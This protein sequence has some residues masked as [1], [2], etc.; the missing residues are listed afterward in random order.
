MSEEIKTMD[1][2][3]KQYFIAL[4][5]I[6]EEKDEGWE[7]CEKELR[8]SFEAAKKAAEAGNAAGQYNLAMHYD[9]DFGVEGTEEQA[10]EWY[11]K[12]AEQGHSEA[13]HYTAWAYLKGQGVKPDLA[14]H[15]E[16]EKKAAFAYYAESKTA[17]AD[18]A[19][20]KIGSAIHAVRFLA[21]DPPDAEVIA[22]FAQMR[23]D[24]KVQ[25]YTARRFSADPNFLEDLEKELKAESKL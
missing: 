18:T 1:Y 12:A 25:A 9:Y 6:V 3:D 24:P 20:E 8:E 10:F 19:E 2:G 14:K 21:D 7:N 22:L 17:E 11:K 15:F 4:R 16:W 23:K 13:M 5:G